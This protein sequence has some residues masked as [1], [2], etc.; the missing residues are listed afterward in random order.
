MI[1]AHKEFSIYIHEHRAGFSFSAGNGH[2]VLTS[3]YGHRYRLKESA[4]C[5]AKNAIN[6]LKV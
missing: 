3:V 4:F 6:R 1:Y 2:T 5:Q